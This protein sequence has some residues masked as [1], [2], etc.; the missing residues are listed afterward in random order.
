MYF[1]ENIFTPV[2][3]NV[4]DV[5]HAVDIIIITNM[6]RG[7]LFCYFLYTTQS[8]SNE[9]LMSQKHSFCI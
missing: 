7:W 2:H 4:I 6:K 1:Q 3:D 5:L 9:K 8:W